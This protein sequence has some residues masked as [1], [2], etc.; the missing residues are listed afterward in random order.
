MKRLVHL[1]SF[2]MLLLLLGSVASAQTDSTDSGTQAVGST[3]DPAPVET[4]KAMTWAAA[5]ELVIEQGVCI[6]TNWREVILVP[7]S[8]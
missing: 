5:E 4:L 3:C 1:S 7:T 6:V 2:L 8:V